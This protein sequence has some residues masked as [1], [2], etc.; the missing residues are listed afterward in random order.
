TPSAAAHV[1]RQVAA[2]LGAAHTAG[3]VHRDVKPENVFLTGDHAHVKVLDFGISK[4]GDSKDGLTKTG[5]VMGTPD[6]M[7]PEQARGDKVDARVDIYA[8]G[9][10]LFR[11]LTGRKPFEGL[12]PWAPLPAVLTQEPPRPHELNSAVPLSLELVIQ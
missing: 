10:I 4:V 7:A 6:Y 1:V 12:D 2:A 11:A 9:A 5:T 8:T 3:I